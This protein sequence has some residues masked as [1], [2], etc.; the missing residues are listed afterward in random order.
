MANW[1][2]NTVEF[3]ADERQ[4]MVLGTFFNALIVKERETNQGQLPDF[5][6]EDGG[7]LFNIYFEEGL[8]QYQTKWA[9]NTRVVLEIGMH[10]K[11]DF[12]YQY[13]E[14]GMGIFGEA[15]YENGRLTV[16]E[17]DNFDLEKFVYD[18]HTESYIFEGAH[19]QTVDEIV[20]IFLERKKL[21]SRKSSN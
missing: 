10:F 6:K 4:M 21:A 11:I 1:C 19:Y 15:I 2:M 20:E 16:F 7:Y 14:Y 9:P 12:C 5:S 18:E 8:L 13:E 3:K 17:L